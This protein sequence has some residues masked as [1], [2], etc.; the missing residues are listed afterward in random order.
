MG[1]D[2]IQKK[3]EARAGKARQVA[4]GHGGWGWGAHMRAQ[5]ACLAARFAPEP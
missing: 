4:W 1:T 3:N 2:G 5:Q